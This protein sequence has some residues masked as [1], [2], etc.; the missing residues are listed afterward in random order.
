MRTGELRWPRYWLMDA[1]RRAGH[2][3]RDVIAQTASLDAAGEPNITSAVGRGYS[4]R[5]AQVVLRSEPA[6]G[7]VQWIWPDIMT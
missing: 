1:H 6:A 7:V 2:L 5:L 4:R 3:E